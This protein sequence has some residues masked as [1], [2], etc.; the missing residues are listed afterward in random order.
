MGASHSGLQVH[1]LEINAT[2]VLIHTNIMY[3]YIYICHLSYIINYILHIYIYIYIVIY[4]HMR[5]CVIYTHVYY[6]M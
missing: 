5:V 4:T 6:V 3:I 2:H 1:H